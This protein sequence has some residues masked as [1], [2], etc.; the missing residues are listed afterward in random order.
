MTIKSFTTSGKSVEQNGTPMGEPVAVDVDGREVTFVPP[1][2]G[3]WAVTMAGGTDSSSPS[4][5][6]ATQ[7]NFFFSMLDPKDVAYFKHRL[8]DREDPFDVDNIA[9]IITYLLEEWAAR[10]TKQPSDYL[11]S[12]RS[13]GKKS[14]AT[15]PHAV[16]TP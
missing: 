14:T 12:Q 8:F 10:P 5:Q 15:R 7:I 9:D 11:P 2:T 16:S 1:T 3:Q 6:V 4:D 13:G